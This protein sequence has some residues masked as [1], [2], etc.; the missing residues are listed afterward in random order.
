MRFVIHTSGEAACEAVARF[1]A[2]AIRREP[3]LVLG[4]P[5]GRTPVPLYRSLVALH[6]VGQVDFRRVTIFN[7]DEFVGIAASHPGAFAAFMQ[8]HLLRH[9]DVAPDRVHMP[10]GDAQR[11]IEEARRYEA[12][13][14][15]AGGID[16]IVLGIGANG[17]VGFNEPASSLVPETHVARL[18]RSTR[19]ANAE[20]FGGNWRRVPRHAISMGVGTMLRAQHVVLLATG[21]AKAD[22]V[23]RALQ[24]PVTTR[25]PASLLQVHPRAVVVLDRAAAARLRRSTSG[26][27]PDG[28]R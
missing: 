1:L 6:R 12:A 25:V 23:A 19:R 4:L 2:H 18:G 21:R 5:S 14:A 11:P 17:H 15:A 10:R 8:R 9:V 26:R 13:I 24:G 22:I 27:R 20:R 28:P 3:D 7:L 16:I